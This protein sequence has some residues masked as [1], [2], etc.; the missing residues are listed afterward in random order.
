[1]GSIN[2]YHLGFYL[3]TKIE[4]ERGLDECFM[5]REIHEDVEAIRM[6]LDYEDYRDLNLF[7][8]SK[9]SD[10]KSIDDISDKEGWKNIRND[11]IGNI[12]DNGIPRV[13]VSDISSEG[14]LILKHTHDGRDLDLEYADNVVDSIRNLWDKDVKFFTIIEEE[15]WEI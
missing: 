5:I 4:K 1:M 15:S 9:K 7:S 14:N 12:G 2:P 13:V 8:Y 10:G 11:L 3:F 6:Y